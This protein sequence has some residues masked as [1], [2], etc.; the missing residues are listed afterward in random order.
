MSDLI[1]F[2]EKY[3][4][5]GL[6]IIPVRQSTK[7]PRVKWKRFIEQA[8]SDTQVY[9][10]FKTFPNANI[11]ALMGRVSG[12]VLAVDV[13]FRNGGE[14]SMKDLELPETFTSRT[15]GGGY[16]FLYRSR[17]TFQ[18]KIGIFPGIDLIADGG[19]CVMP[20]SLHHSGIRYEIHKDL[21]IEPAP[22]W[23]AALL[24]SKTERENSPAIHA[25]LIPVGERHESIKRSILAYATESFYLTHLWK[26]A[27]GLAVKCCEPSD[28]D[29]FTIGELFDLCLWAWNKAHPHDLFHPQIA[30]KLLSGCARRRGDIY[31]GPVNA[32]LQ[33]LLPNIPE[34]QPNNPTTQ[35]PKTVTDTAIYIDSILGGKPVWK[36]D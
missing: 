16:H 35:L 23:L 22:D 26:R 34:K 11:A 10:W 18:K 13:D 5:L 1:N 6:A 29:P 19:Y 24:L 33:P 17:V 25:P 8:P 3:L 15:G 32:P 30:W 31:F 36:K 21:P 4:T 7:I 20:P 12:N 14:T 27:Y 2:V 9:D 28:E